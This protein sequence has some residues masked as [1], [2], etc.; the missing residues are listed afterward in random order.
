MLSWIWTSG[1][2]MFRKTGINVF[3]LA[4]NTLCYLHL[5]LANNNNFTHSKWMAWVWKVKKFSKTILSLKW[6]THPVLFFC[7]CFLIFGTFDSIGIDYQAA[8]TTMWAHF[9]MEV[10]I[11]CRG[12]TNYYWAIAFSKVNKWKNREGVLI[13]RDVHCCFSPRSFVNDPGNF[14]WA[15]F[16]LIKSPRHSA[17]LAISIK[18]KK[19][20]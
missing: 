4:G 11:N 17:N 18:K 13:L 8:S 10:L 1:K 9:H 14:F 3:A 19:K 2:S 7:F 16:S 5:L 15:F 6:S 20:T 12:V